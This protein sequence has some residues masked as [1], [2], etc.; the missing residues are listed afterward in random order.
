MFTGIFTSKMALARRVEHLEASV[1]SVHQLAT[2]QHTMLKRLQERLE[3]LEDAHERLRGKFYS[4]RRPHAEQETE[5][6][7]REERK[8]QAFAKFGIQPGK[9]INLE[10]T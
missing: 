7:S 1:T 5:P 4:A 9:P 10:R 8:K 6:G 3:A 2:D